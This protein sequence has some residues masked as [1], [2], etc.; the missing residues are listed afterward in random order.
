MRRVRLCRWL[1]PFGNEKRCLGCLLARAEELD[2]DLIVLAA[3]GKAETQ[4]FWTGS[5]AAPGQGKTSRSTEGDV[6]G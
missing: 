1:E 5:I 6:L 3:H 4:A 2:V